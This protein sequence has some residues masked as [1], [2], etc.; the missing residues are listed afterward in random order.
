MTITR[1]LH[2]ALLVSNLARAEKFYQDV[3]GLTKSPSRSLSFSGTWYQIGDLQLHLIENEYYKYSVINQDKWG[4]NPHFAL[5]VDNLDA[6]EQKLERANYAI[7]MSS[8]G[9]KALFTQDPDNNII[10]LSQ[11]IS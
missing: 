3:L 11:K 7:Q 9:R 10:E 2:A 1:C 8:S 5:E 6:I 4:R